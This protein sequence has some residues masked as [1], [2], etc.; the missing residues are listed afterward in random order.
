[1]SYGIAM[2]YDQV[3]THAALAVAAL[4]SIMPGIMLLHVARW[5]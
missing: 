4:H 3:I 2:C 5:S 1:M